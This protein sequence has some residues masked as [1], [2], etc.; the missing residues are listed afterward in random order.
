MTVVLRIASHETGRHVTKKLRK[1]INDV[2]LPAG[3]H[4]EVVDSQGHNALR[5]TKA[6]FAQGKL[7][8]DYNQGD[9]TVQLRIAGEAIEGLDSNGPLDLNAINAAFD[10]ANPAEGAWA[11]ADWGNA[12]ADAQGSGGT[13][14]SDDRHHGVSG[15]LLL[16]LGLGAAGG[17]AGALAGGGGG[18][19]AAATP[20]TAPAA[21][22]V[23]LGNGVGT[24]GA[25][26]AEATQTSGVVTVSAASGT[27]IDVTFT[28]GTHTLTKTVTGTGSAVAV[29]LTSADLTTL[30]D[31]AIA[32]SAVAK[33]N[34][35][36]SSAAT[37]S[38]T[39]DTTGPVAPTLALSADTGAS[40][41]DH[42]TS[43]GSVSLTAETGASVVLTF[44]N[45]SH[46]LTKT[47]TG[48]GSAQT[49]TLSSSDMASLG[50]GAV[51]VSAVATDVAGNAGPAGM[52]SYTL[53]TATVA[54]ITSQP[55]LVGGTPVLTG[56]AEAGDTVIV[57]IAGATYQ[58]TAIGGTW[59]I[60]TA[61]ATPSSG[62]LALNTNGI[63]AVGVTATDGAGNTAT[64]AQNL[65]LVSA[66]S[67][68]VN[69][70]ATN[71]AVQV[72]SIDGNVPITINAPN[73]TSLTITGNPNGSPVDVTIVDKTPGAVDSYPLTLIT[74]VSPAGNPG[75]PNLLILDFASAQDR[76]VLSSASSVQGF[77]QIEV[78]NGTLDLSGVNLTGIV[79]IQINSGVVLTLAQFEAL[80]SLVSLSG[81]GQLTIHLDTQSQISDLITFLQSPGNLFLMGTTVTVEY[82]SSNT[83]I[84]N[85]TAANLISAL[86]YPSIPQITNAIS[87]LQS[88]VGGN[89]AAIALL[90]NDASAHGG[91]AT[92]ASITGI[93]AA[94]AALQAQ[95]AQQQLDLNAI[96]AHNLDSLETLVNNLSSAMTSLTAQVNTQATQI[97]A[98]TS[99]IATQ[100]TQIAGL[101]TNVGALQTA[102][103]ALQTGN[104]DNAA[105]ITAL[106]AAHNSLSAT[107]SA[108]QTTLQNDIATL[109][110]ANYANA[111]Y[112]DIASL[113]AQIDALNSAVA[114]LQTLVGPS[115]VADQISAAIGHP[116]NGS[117]AATG[118]W[119]AIESA[120][121][122]AVAGL[123]TEIDN[124]NANLAL[125]IDDSSANGGTATLNSIAGLLAAINVLNGSGAGS[126]AAQITAAIGHPTNGNGAATGLWV[127]IESAIS[128]ATATLQTEIN[129][130]NANL[131]LVI[132]DSSANG[133]TPTLNSIAG[134]LAAINV[135]NGSGAGSVSSQIAAAI[136]HP[137]NGSGAATGLWADIETAINTET[138]SLSAQIA[139]L[140]GS[141]YNSAAYQ[142][143]A[144][145]SAA[146][147]SLQSLVGNT[148]VSSQIT[149][150]INGVTNSFNTLISALH[151][152]GVVVTVADTEAL[153]VSDPAQLLTNYRLVDT[154]ANLLAATQNAADANVFAY[155]KSI[156]FTSAAP[157]TVAQV[158]GLE[159]AIAAIANAAPINAALN[160]YSLSDT[161]AHL[162]LAN[163]A[164][165]S[166]AIN[167]TA[168]L[169][170]ASLD[171]VAT[172]LAAANA[173]VTLLDAVSGTP[174]QILGLPLGAHDTITAIT[175]TGLA[176]AQQAADLV[177]LATAGK[178]GSVQLGAVSDTAANIEAVI[179]HQNGA[180]FLSTATRIDVSGT[181]T[182][183][184]AEQ[185]QAVNANVHITAIADSAASI[186]SAL[187][188]HQLSLTYVTALSTTD[189]ATIAQASA[190]QAALPGHVSI[191]GITDTSADIGAAVLAGTLSLTGVGSVAIADGSIADYASAAQAAA[192]GR[193]TLSLAYDIADTSAHY[194]STIATYGQSFLGKAGNIVLSGTASLAVAR[195][196]LS[197]HNSGTVTI[198]T[199]NATAAQVGSLNFDAHDLVTNL[200]VAGLTFGNQTV[201]LT[202]VPFSTNLTY[203]GAGLGSSY[204]LMIYMP[205]PDGVNVDGNGVNQAGTVTIN[206]GSGNN[207]FVFTDDLTDG[208]Y[209][210]TAYGVGSSINY[211]TYGNNQHGTETLVIIGSVDISNIAL[212]G[213]LNSYDLEAFA[214]S[215]SSVTLSATQLNKLHNFNGAS[216]G[217][218]INIT[219]APDPA[220]GTVV[221]TSSSNNTLTQNINFTNVIG[222]N[223]GVNDNLQIDFLRLLGLSHVTTASG[224]GSSAQSGLVT[225]I[226]NTAGGQTYLTTDGTQNGTPISS[227]FLTNASY[228]IDMSA[229]AGLSLGNDG[230]GHYY[231]QDSQGNHLDLPQTLNGSTLALSPDEVSGSGAPLVMGAT[232]GGIL[233]LTGLV[234][235]GG[236]AV[237]ITHVTAPIRV[238]I[239]Q[240]A[241]LTG[242]GNPSQIT[243]DLAHIA[244][245]PGSSITVN[246]VGGGNPPVTLTMTADQASNVAISGTGE[247]K[248]IGTATGNEDY[249]GLTATTVDLSGIDPNGH[250]IT[251]P[252]SIPS[253]HTLIL[254]QA[255][256]NGATIT[257]TGSLNILVNSAATMDLSHIDTSHLSVS[258]V[259]PTGTSATVP[260][261]SNLAN[262]PI[263]VQSGAT[264]TIDGDVASGKTI[265]GAGTVVVTGTGTLNG[266]DDFSHITAHTVDLSAYTGTIAHLPTLSPTGVAAL[267]LNTAEA[268]FA[269]AAAGNNLTVPS[270]TSLTVVVHGPASAPGTTLDMSGI[271]TTG[272]G[273]LAV[274]VTGDTVLSSANL[275]GAPVSVDA[276]VTLTMPVNAASGLHITGAGT[277]D[278]FGGG[279]VTA[280]LSNL[281]AAHV[282]WE[283]TQD[284]T[285]TG[286]LG[287]AVVTIDH[288][289][290]LSG[291]AAR[292]AGATV[293]AGAVNT[294][295]GES[296]GVLSIT[297]AFT[298]QDFSLV[299][300]SLD[301]SHATS[302]IVTNLTLPTWVAGQSLIMSYA[303]VDG[304]VLDVGAGDA[305]IVNIASN[306][307]S[308]LSTITSTSGHVTAII[309]ATASFGGTFSSAAN[310]SIHFITGTNGATYTLSLDAVLLD[311]RSVDGTGTVNVTT[312]SASTDLSAVLPSTIDF[313]HDSALTVV[314]GNLTEG[315]AT[316]TLP[317]LSA[318]HVLALTAAQANTLVVAGS[319]GTVDV[320]GDV[321]ANADLTAIAAGIAISFADASDPQ[322]GAQITIADAHTLTMA[323]DQL[324][325]QKVLADTAHNASGTLVVLG[326]GGAA[327][328]LT[329]AADLGAVAATID[330]TGITNLH[331]ASG[332]LEDATTASYALTLPTL[333]SS[334]TLLVN[335][336]QLGG[337]ALT[338]S[339]VGTA[340][341]RGDV[342]SVSLNLSGLADTVHLSLLDNL[343]NAIDIDTGL[344]LTVKAAHASNQTIT[345]SGSLIV[346]D[347]SAHAAA[348]VADLS[349]VSAET[350]DLTQFA[351]LHVGGGAALDHLVDATGTLALTLPVL[352]NGQTLVL[353]TAQLDGDLPLQVLGSGTVEVTGTLDDQAINLTGIA[354]ANTILFDGGALTMDHGAHLTAT[355]GQLDGQTIATI[356]ADST[357]TLADAA[358]APVLSAAD[359]TAALTAN[360]N[361]AILGNVVDTAANLATLDWGNYGFLTSVHG[362]VTATTAATLAQASVLFNINYYRAGMATFSVADTLAHFTAAPQWLIDQAVERASFN[363]GTITIT[364]P[365][366]LA[367]AA[368]LVA[369]NLAYQTNDQQQ[370]DGQ[371]WNG[372]TFTVSDSASALAALSNSDATSLHDALAFGGGS[373]TV[374]G[375][376]TAAQASTL[377]AAYGALVHYSVADTAAAIVARHTADGNWNFLTDAAAVEVTGGTSAA[378]AATLEASGVSGL[379]IDM[380]SD[381]AANIASAITAN[382]H[383]LDSVGRVSLTS[384]V[385][386][387]SLGSAGAQSVDFVSDTVANLMTMVPGSYT[388]LTASAVISATGTATAA[389]AQTILQNY[390]NYLGGGNNFPNATNEKTHL[391]ISIAD[392]AA[393]VTALGVA[394]L[395][396]LSGGVHITDAANATQGVELAWLGANS[397]AHIYYSVADSA[398]NLTAQ[399][400]G[401]IAARVTGTITATTAATA[402]QAYTLYGLATANGVSAPVLFTLS[403]SA[404]NVAVAITAHGAT[405][406][407]GAAAIIVTDTVTVAQASAILAA[408]GQNASVSFAS[409]SDTAAAVNG[410]NAGLLDH[411][412][413]TVTKVLT[414]GSTDLSGVSANIDLRGM[415]AQGVALDA[416]TS[417]NTIVLNQLVS[418]AGNTLT[419]EAYS[420]LLPTL[421][422]TQ[423]LYVDAAQLAGALAAAV[424]GS[425]HLVLA[426]DIAANTDLTGVG[427]TI[428]VSFK[429]DG[430]SGTF[431]TVALGMGAHL[432]AHDAQISAHAIT[433]AG[434]LIVLGGGN[435]GHLSGALD[436]SSI[437]AGI[438][439]TQA[440]LS[441]ETTP[442]AHQ[443][444]LVDNGY[445][446]TLPVLTGQTVSL[447]I[448]ELTGQLAITGT[449]TLDLQ[450]DIT[451]SLDLTYLPATIALSFLDG[452]DAG[453]LA[454]VNVSGTA[455]AETVLTLSAEQASDQYITGNAYARIELPY[456]ASTTTN[457]SDQ[458]D[459]A[460]VFSTA[461]ATNAAWAG[462]LQAANN[463]LAGKI[464]ATD[465]GVV[466]TGGNSDGAF[467]NFQFTASATGTYTF[468]ANFQNNYHGAYSYTDS[469]GTHTY[470]PDSDRYYIT[471]NING[472]NN[473]VVGW[474]SASG[475][476]TY[477]VTMVEGETLSIYLYT[478]S[479]RTA[480]PDG[481]LTSPSTLTLSDGGF[482]TV[483]GTAA[484]LNVTVGQDTDLSGAADPL[485][486][487]PVDLFTLANNAV[488]TMTGLEANGHTVSGSG[489]VVISGN[490]VSGWVD[491]T[492]VMTPMTF[493][494]SVNDEEVLGI[495]G[496]NWLRLTATQAN[497]LFTNGGTV[498]IGGD[499]ADGANA[500]IDLTHIQSTLSFEDTSL[501][502]RD[503]SA[504]T[505]L[506]TP[507][508]ISRNELN[509]LS[510]TNGWNYGQLYVGSSNELVLRADQANW[511]SV[512]GSGMTYVVGNVDG[513]DLSLLGIT[514]ALSFWDGIV[515][516]PYGGD[517]TED[518][519]STGKGS[520]T[521]A[522]QSTMEVI[523]NQLDGNYILGDGSNVV[524]VYGALGDAGHAIDLS[525]ITTSIDLAY[526]YDHNVTLVTGLNGQGNVTTNNGSITVGFNALTGGQKITIANSISG[527]YNTLSAYLPQT[528]NADQTVTIYSRD[529]T[530]L[531][532]DTRN[533]DNGSI[534]LDEGGNA[535]GAKVLISHVED[536]LSNGLVNGDFSQ[537][538]ASL[539]TLN[540]GSRQGSVL[541]YAGSFGSATVLIDDGVNVVMD[542][543]V[544][545]GVY[546]DTQYNGYRWNGSGF[547]V[548]G[549]N[550]LTANA[551]LTNTVNDPSSFNL[552]LPN[553]YGHVDIDISYGAVGSAYLPNGAAAITWNAGLGQFTNG[554]YAITL[555]TFDGENGL[556]VNASQLSGG[557]GFTLDGSGFVGVE[558]N[559]A[560]DL[561]LTALNT[562][563]AV[564]FGSNATNIR[565]LAHG[566]T[567]PAGWDN[568]SAY[569]GTA[570]STGVAL[571]LRPDQVYN[572]INVSGAGTLA[573]ASGAFAY[574]DEFGDVDLI[575]VTANIDLTALGS[576]TGSSGG[577]AQD[578]TRYGTIVNYREGNSWIN[579]TGGYLLGNGGYQLLL[580]TL[581]AT[582]NLTVNA[583]Q[584][585]GN[586]G[587]NLS[588]TVNGANRSL[589]DIKG[590]VN[591]HVVLTNVTNSVTVSFKDGSETGLGV[592]TVNASGQLVARIDQL[593]TQNINGAGTVYA[594][595]TGTVP[596]ISAADASA[597][598]QMATGH[599]ADLTGISANLDLTALSTTNT[600]AGLTIN[601]SG[602]F[603]DGTDATKLVD[604]PALVAGQ[605]LTVTAREMTGQLAL[606]K[607]A[608]NG[609]GTIDIQGN[610]SDTTGTVDLTHVQDGI[611][612]SFA[613]NANAD[614]S[615]AGSSAQLVIKGDQA[616]GLTITG[617]G[618][619][620]AA[621]NNAGSSGSRFTGAAVVLADNDNG[622][623][624][625][626]SG[627]NSA[628][629]DLS[630]ISANLDL[631]GLTGMAVDGNGALSDGQGK[632]SLGTLRAQQTVKVNA[633]QLASLS[634]GGTGRVIL[635]GQTGSI[636]D[637]RGNIASGL[638]VNL[639]GIVG[640]TV[641]FVDTADVTANAISV[642]GTLTMLAEQ[643]DAAGG[644][645]ISG[646]GA[647]WLNA[648]QAVT[649]VNWTD[650][651]Q[652]PSYYIA[653]TG[654]SS[655]LDVQASTT[656]VAGGGGLMPTTMQ[657]KVENSQ[658]LTSGYAYVSGRTIYDAGHVYSYD[659]QTGT[660]TVT[661]GALVVT[662]ASGGT[663]DLSHVTVGTL[664]L[665]QYSG[666]S[667]S[668]LW[669]DLTDHALLMND[670]QASTHAF[671]AG[672]NGGALTVMATA[673]ATYHDFSG[674]DASVNS[675]LVV[676][677]AA[678][679]ADA[680]SGG[681]HT[682][683]NVFSHV[684]L[685]YTTGQ[686]TVSADQVSGMSWSR[687]TGT[688]G[689]YVRD[690]AATYHSGAETLYGTNNN[691]TFAG[692]G[693]GDTI[694]LTGSTSAKGGTDTIAFSTLAGSNG[695]TVDF[696]I[697]GF[698]TGAGLGHDILNFSALSSHTAHSGAGDI[699][700]V[701]LGAVPSTLAQEV[702][703]VTDSFGAD[704]SG[705]ASVFGAGSNLLNKAL[706]AVGNTDAVFI[707]ALSDPNDGGSG[708][709]AVNFGI[710]HWQATNGSNGYVHAGELTEIGV[711]HGLTQT[712]IAAMTSANVIG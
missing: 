156:G 676:N 440:L 640:S 531:S 381:S 550:T 30:G 141:N 563:F 598:Q 284:A 262:F 93:Q 410:A 414:S 557:T 543:A 77:N 208:T 183:A 338:L 118:L 359:I 28:N 684:G 177:S 39:L 295:L 231:L 4:V 155:A 622:T 460:H 415:S 163:P 467:E 356:D 413:G 110:G 119:A 105:A 123:Q 647:L 18:G 232:N 390:Y 2:T 271:N 121:S 325:G 646:T 400:T 203:N 673:P 659:A 380:V 260:S 490:I 45:G 631:T 219:N 499:I 135:L 52:L 293:L 666:T 103:A 246:N 438:D 703:V 487:V 669:T 174:A 700:A 54:G 198:E 102:V 658:T 310:A 515:A 114:A 78:R 311:G 184:E 662:G 607:A 89:T 670:N 230:S 63:N 269:S 388:K 504:Y 222:V 329:S 629:V 369:A 468:T 59:S 375:T 104:S 603:A 292:F 574:E 372:I 41:S 314:S 307:S 60:D 367:D 491:L 35:L 92:T 443:G 49:V 166:G 238:S 455:Q 201:D 333:V 24:N 15:T 296:R 511:H 148:S 661:G 545:S 627:A 548:V 145:I 190:L 204:S 158:T 702:I 448:A 151:G 428:D 469:Y 173:G 144:S 674:I 461:F 691:D 360:A 638:S 451:S 397:G 99:D 592:A 259:V 165:L 482:S 346:V 100:A 686:L 117:G 693:Y 223:I 642:T 391:L 215:P 133:G 26:A 279:A 76:V 264:L 613:D 641:S 572:H 685:D 566:Q 253:G 146:I 68:V 267:V 430:E 701:S 323:S 612:V 477:T 257:G 585:A 478:P 385:A 561:D 67:G 551:D 197:A 653:N 321:A 677:G 283:V 9:D 299:G 332:V 539:V 88:A 407:G 342:A 632:L 339:G 326:R 464:A 65:Q 361:A 6:E 308:D 66:S 34:G 226:F 319:A 502:S 94:L 512:S 508:T 559:I 266:G 546:F 84:S 234:N 265:S 316:V 454:T 389:Q 113:S 73:A 344:A 562:D 176:S 590:T 466:L 256:V 50:D 21:P 383:F 178:A 170:G 5:P 594:G 120:I 255:E 288:D 687:F 345:G 47:V 334:Q 180:T 643:F 402:E 192:L 193:S 83:V 139:A 614:L 705:V 277:V 106:Q 152:A 576:D 71:V 61:T 522:D 7:I 588:G 664:D 621:Y 623:L 280:D 306:T 418:S 362:T 289:V 453:G 211:A 87:A 225:P 317:A 528:W 20:A 301:L 568:W 252:A 505:A 567:Y 524:R 411:V 254:N 447:T 53:D 159:S 510:Y 459:L 484:E 364:D 420:V 473:Q 406:L 506:N 556:I 626:L 654:L 142:D 645:K 408:A 124:T 210:P 520:I 167:I 29:V 597:L 115:S 541:S 1:G 425:G 154:Y 604:L 347:D 476:T 179:A 270:G 475:S 445:Y 370:V 501:T 610:M 126:V 48:T 688:G 51:S 366:S 136:G 368:A 116:T 235:S 595:I 194:A 242:V 599:T 108:L 320:Q 696:S 38:F 138:A 579:Y 147:T 472:G 694:D 376:A 249:S 387:A 709:P 19:A 189:T 218:I 206:A 657:I 682:L 164:I 298:T 90:I 27:T 450:G 698:T 634:A 711:L 268:D 544:A 671:T 656:L 405:F 107:V 555:P 130:T 606:T 335:A 212:G 62:T 322:S 40:N 258:L 470:N 263:V 64:A 639:T 300:A 386:V 624:S 575:S 14:N 396:R 328:A 421:A 651:A 542:G 586:N 352:A 36:S 483:G 398:A 404:A 692:G 378:N 532:L 348:L 171:Q 591:S 615:I 650:S 449:G 486:Y 500:L 313:T 162:A 217:T 616:S 708:A 605:T 44:T 134:L 275:N 536:L 417:R 652:T 578:G 618:T 16:L 683:L 278:L 336:D 635:N 11:S 297:G 432:T 488:L 354:A 46:S 168:T 309:D 609:G 636:V 111:T 503:V 32:V 494:N 444:Q 479:G 540:F 553:I 648:T 291:S 456:A 247:V 302:G 315:S 8:L 363:G 75:Q 97:A 619:S 10:S 569:S 57:T 187:S 132:D 214:G 175:V 207:T 403:D 706:A 191:L 518:A 707:V 712:Q 583:D 497:G 394:D 552:T 439:L 101:L 419:R 23:A 112:K 644:M 227:S 129:N 530:D 695:H 3:A 137:T 489:A 31:G 474:T 617:D 463:G 637:V 340:D 492:H 330:L 286:T 681:N 527:T 481:A 384:G 580:P 128:A 91:T 182:V 237:D 86:N 628:T 127:G 12:E 452:A 665:T 261:G 507:T 393:H 549:I 143:I 196:L 602:K 96:A 485:A 620:A 22:V 98:N 327:T 611:D 285:F 186:T 538:N 304:L 675:L 434:T 169:S 79:D 318:G 240:N 228:N 213:D 216:G 25:N 82:G 157:L 358:P 416:N 422:A 224:S 519:R 229:A 282:N 250:T 220:T 149:N 424:A 663:L 37:N 571:T 573:L 351:G 382:S 401:A 437:S 80:S 188:A 649:T 570:V 399:I 446:I 353:T 678:N 577:I 672:G 710:W 109:Q 371:S 290:T 593:D 374:T 529:A 221:V 608:Q 564:Y 172:V 140:Q 395:A 199:I 373:I 633:A 337:G 181:L 523:G 185:L 153:L 436:L 689:L 600:L 462:A 195:S 131:A 480:G 426:G 209:L 697:S 679:M 81:L 56:T 42:I 70:N 392:T 554:T 587:F 498:N 581:G 355:A 349:H 668:G 43:N 281:T 273:T 471:T 251:L 423:T 357:I 287:S 625:T 526:A 535:V 200:N 161:V 589:L 514:S 160:S 517:D 276:A 433:G 341:V 244:S 13:D 205:V 584:L 202:N 582:Q 85:S 458:T 493:T 243:T 236:D 534:V 303:Q 680:I 343:D 412:S 441:V 521:L 537:I 516:N 241:D 150:A 699:S 33:A 324:T 601:G 525:H 312:V 547:G 457:L 125:V 95:V 409:L 435:G 431:G 704:A 509:T 248:V 58:T 560:A 427:A 630:G 465:T 245:I 379:A 513:S 331:V 239:G 667:F 495:N 496:D 533:Y 365:V 274:H 72:N 655:T 74:N 377:V 565:N 350:I 558:G 690:D 69:T 233:Q 660:Y 596:Q 294:G 272:T 429:D 442:G 122:T 55:I 305:R 17:L